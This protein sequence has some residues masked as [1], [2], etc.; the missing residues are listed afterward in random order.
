MKRD[1][2][3]V[4]KKSKK[5]KE[6]AKRGRPEGSGFKPTDEQRKLVESLAGY[7]ITEVEISK[8]VVNPQTNAPISPVTLRKC[9]RD[10]LDRGH[11]IANHQVAGAL[12]KNATTGTAAFPGGNPTSQIFWLKTRGKGQ[13]RDK[14][15]IEVETPP[16]ELEEREIDDRIQRL[17]S[18]AK[19]KGARHGSEQ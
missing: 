8:L 13:W 3:P 4:A 6:P 17:L 1:A 15:V 9:F 10:E 2:E 19:G 14:Q 12:F 7:G 5:H 11:V 18:K 16:S